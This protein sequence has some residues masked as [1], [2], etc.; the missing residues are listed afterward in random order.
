MSGMIDFATVAQQFTAYYYQ[1]FASD[2]NGL[3]ALYTNESCLTFE[4]SQVMGKDAIVSKLGALGFN[5]VQHKIT[6]IDSQPVLGVDGNKAVFV[7]VIGKLVTDDDPEKGFMQ[8]FLLR[9]VDA[10]A[11]SF[12]IANETFR[13]AL[14]D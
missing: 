11:S 14:F 12:F 13:L 2:R 8:N 5:K 3:T 4:G 6:K 9:P 10:S 1:L 7:T